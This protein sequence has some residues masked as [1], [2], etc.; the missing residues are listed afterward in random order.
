MAR[1][2]IIEP[3][4]NGFVVKVGCQTVV[5]NKLDTLMRLLSEYFVTPDLIE[6]DFIKTLRRGLRRSRSL[7]PTDSSCLAS[8]GGGK[9]PLDIQKEHQRLSSCIPH[10]RHKSLMLSYMEPPALVSLLSKDSP[11]PC[12]GPLLRSGRAEGE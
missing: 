7:T 9:M 4:L 10:A 12:L 5:F 2:I 6:Q 11:T 8:L 3:C 1:T